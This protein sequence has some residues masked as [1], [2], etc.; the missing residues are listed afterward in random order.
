[1]S[2]VENMTNAVYKIK[3]DDIVASV[4]GNNLDA[5]DNIASKLITERACFRDQL[6]NV[7]KDAKSSRFNKCA[8]AYHLGEMRTPEAA[9][10]LAADIKLNLG[11]MVVDHLSILMHTPAV[12][13][14]IK[15]GSPSIPAVIRNL[16]EN[17]DAKVRELS[18]KVLYRIDGDKDIV[19][20]RLQK[21]LNAQKDSQK[22]ARL[23]AA[24][25]SLGETQFDK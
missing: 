15:I 23:Q 18:L 8:A 7:F 17:G 12:D 16:E 1:M 6:L 22:Q 25:K 21:A 20:L 9:D 10:A 14:L 11:P 13:A 24:L 19:R 5:F 4:K 3:P 2:Q